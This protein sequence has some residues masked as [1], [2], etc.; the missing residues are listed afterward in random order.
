LWVA[1]SAAPTNVRAARRRFASWLDE[2]A[3]P[4]AE[5]DDILLAVNEA[6]DNV[7]DHAYPP[8]LIGRAH[9]N[10]WQVVEHSRR[11]V[12]AVVTDW[13]RWKPPPQEPG[14]RGRGLL[15][16]D[17]CTDNVVVQPSRRGTTVILI[18]APVPLS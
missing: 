3:W 1:L 17:A 13:G 14:Y 6:L 7:A 5:R 10:S 15:M 11:H 12:V 18:S 4:A 8:G 9:L 2:L 16:M